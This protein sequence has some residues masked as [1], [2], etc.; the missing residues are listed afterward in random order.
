[1]PATE[2]KCYSF[3]TT[4]KKQG[5]YRLFEVFENGEHLN[6]T[7]VLNFE[8]INNHNRFKLDIAPDGRIRIL[9]SVEFDGCTFRIKEGSTNG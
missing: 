7:D 8:D 2:L 6:Y 9:N 4:E 1:M 5:E 3:K